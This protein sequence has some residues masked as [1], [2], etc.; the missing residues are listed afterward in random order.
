MN[1]KFLNFFKELVEASGPAGYEQQVQEVY[2]KFVSPCADKVET[3]VHGN[4]IAFKKGTGKKRVMLSGHADEVG[5]MVKY[6]DDSGYVWFS[7]IGFVDCGLLPGLRVNIFHGGDVVRGVVGVLPVHMFEGFKRDKL[8]TTADLWI[9][10]G[11]KDK[12]EAEKKVSVG[13]YITFSSGLEMLPNNLITS[14]ATDNRAAV[15]TVASVLSNLAKEKINAN[16]YS[17]SSVQEELFYRGAT[18]SAYRIEPHIGIALDVTHTTD[19][20]QASGKKTQIGDIKLNEGVT[21]AVGPNIN[22]RVAELLKSAAKTAKIKYQIEPIPMPT[23]TDANAMQLSK[24]GVATGL[25]SIPCRYMHS[26]SEIIS[27]ADLEGAVTLLTQFCKMIDDDTDLI[28]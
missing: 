23:Y 8:I 21:I 11:A 13:D 2:R 5:F 24:A 10:I 28:P 14:K 15:F 17:V 19:F 7:P 6:I 4:V 22:P 16:I 1:E 20:P 18:T 9:D 27:L 3:D 12:K 26:P 25:L